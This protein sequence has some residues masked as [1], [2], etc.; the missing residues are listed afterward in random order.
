MRTSVSLGLVLTVCA[1]G[2][3]AAPPK[4]VSER[5]IHG[6]VNPESV[7]CDPAGKAIY[8][9]NFGAPKL[10]PGKKEPTGY[11]SKLSLD[12]KLLDEKYLPA[13]GA[14]P[15]HKPKGI[16][17]ANGKLW[18][19]DIDSVREFDLK[20]RK[21]RKVD[22]PGE[23]VFANDPAIWGG[24]LY[25]TDNRN[26]LLFKIEPADF[27]DAKAAP[28]VVKVLDRAGSA[29][30]AS[31]A[32]GIR[33]AAA[34]GARVINCSV[35]TP[36]DAPALRE[37]IAFAASAGALV[38]ASAGN[39]HEPASSGR[40]QAAAIAAP[41][42]IA[43]AATSPR[44]GRRLAALSNF[45]RTTIGLAAPGEGV[46]STA[47]DGGYELRSGTSMAA[48]YVSGVAALI[49][50]LR[51]G[52]L[53]PDLRA[54]ILSAAAPS[55]LPISAGYLDAQAAVRAVTTRAVYDLGQRPQVQVVRADA[56]RTMLLLNTCALGATAAIRG[57]RIEVGGRRVARVRGREVLHLLIR[58]V[59]RAAGRRIGVRALGASGRTIAVG[60]ARVAVARE[61]KPDIGG[62]KVVRAT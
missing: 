34:N 51:P 4:V 14:E 12:G 47:R 62:A 20:T 16:W 52:I 32:E 8:V 44:D 2:V 1:A 46:L 57:Y 22:L 59:R 27:L 45:G 58:G 37:A 6:F 55:T 60:S 54:A 24:A 42:V 10:D 36:D 39:E 31:T 30:I 18:V 25:V 33:Y 29:S 23:N 3:L 49:V 15:L 43:V 19:T 40:S 28:K 17:I 41:N 13:K 53:G 61:T 48:P 35:A 7:G 50:G 21:D 9:G 26:D 5:T 38:V 56:S 11:I